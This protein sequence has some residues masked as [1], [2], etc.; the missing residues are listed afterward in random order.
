VKIEP[1]DIHVH[2][3]VRPI[4][5]PLHAKRAIEHPCGRH[6]FSSLVRKVV[7]P[8]IVERE[9]PKTP[10]KV[11]PSPIPSPS[12]QRPEAVSEAPEPSKAS[13]ASPEFVTSPGLYDTN[14]SPERNSSFQSFSDDEDIPIMQDESEFS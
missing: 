9:A 10:E 11:V 5:A 7:A 13:L 2:A 14:S 4:V 3:I 1:G 12:P 6:V 8:C